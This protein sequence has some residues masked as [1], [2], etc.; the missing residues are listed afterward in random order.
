MR[1]LRRIAAVALACACAPPSGDAPPLHP[2]TGEAARELGVVELQRLVT[3]P[4]NFVLRPDEAAGVAADPTH[5]LVYTGSREGTLLAIDHANGEVV[6]ERDLAGP[7][8]STPVVVDIGKDG[9]VLLV[10]TDNG[11]LFAL[12]PDTHE[13]RWHYVT[14]GRIRNQAVVLEG[15]VYF[16]NSRDQVFAL[17][18]RTGTWRWQ[19]EQV[20]QTDFTVFGHAGLTLAPSTDPAAPESASVLA[21]F[22]N[23]KVVALSA[24]AG[25]ALWI[26]SVAPAAGGNFVD[27]DATPLL[28]L[29]RG[30]VFVSGQSTGVHALKLQDGG[31]VWN[32]PMRGAGTVVDAPGAM[33]VVASSLEGVFGLDRDGRVLWRRQL[34]P[35]SLSRPLVVDDTIVLTHSDAGLVVLDAITGDMLGKLFTGS[36]MSSVPSWDPIERR[37]YAI[38]NRGTLI[39]VR[40]H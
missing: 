16:V 9:R 36:G 27:C 25:E 29:E 30:L 18:V 33:L 2:S 5:G 12:D 7:V 28:D 34:D 32:F 15:V 20:L 39:G 21:C 1:A 14:D 4:D 22:D 26:G 23:G 10:G 6:W 8:A 31:A 40:V 11:V 35:G 37:V 17:D 13:E 38:T 24:G 19:Y 3:V